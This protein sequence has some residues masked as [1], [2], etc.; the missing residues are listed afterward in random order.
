MMGLQAV[1]TS[2]GWISEDTYRV[3]AYLY[4]TPYYFDYR[5]RFVEDEI[6][7]DGGINV[8][9]NGAE[10]QTLNGK[11]EENRAGVLP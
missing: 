2:S 3:R 1:A 11:R 6:F 8:S 5:F 7:L 9:F 10:E 4:E